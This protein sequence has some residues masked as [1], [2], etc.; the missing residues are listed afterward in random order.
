MPHP[1]LNQHWT[2]FLH[3]NAPDPH[4]DTYTPTN[5]A[6]F[7]SPY[8]PFPPSPPDLNIHKL[9]FPP[10][11]PLPPDYP[12]IINAVTDEVLTL[13]AFHART[14]AL[15]RALRHDG[16]NPLRLRK[17]PEHDGQEGEILGLFSRN[18]IHYPEVVHAC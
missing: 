2:R 3:P 12:L 16:V 17:S 18:H 5:T 6:I 11:T 1:M 9:C 15:S 8:G 14:L 10:N 13:H 7:T 4:K